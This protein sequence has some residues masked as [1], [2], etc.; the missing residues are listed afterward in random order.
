M[1]TAAAPAA[2]TESIAADWEQKVGKLLAELCDLQDELLA[3][4]SERQALLSSGNVSPPDSL[5]HRAPALASRLAACRQRRAELLTRASHEQAR[6]G[7]LLQNEMLTEWIRAQR[8]LLE[9]SQELE[10]FATGRPPAAE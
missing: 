3:L 8:L 5:C 9:L 7:T 4:L 10:T 1:S 6:L 2:L